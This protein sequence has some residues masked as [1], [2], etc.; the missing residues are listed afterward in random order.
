LRKIK[1]HRTERFNKLNL[2]RLYVQFSYLSSWLL[3][4]NFI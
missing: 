1:K 3:S 4:G 2:L